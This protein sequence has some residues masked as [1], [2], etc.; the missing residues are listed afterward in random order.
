MDLRSPSG[1]R[2]SVSIWLPA[3][4]SFRP[5]PPCRDEEHAGRA[6]Q[7]GDNAIEEVAADD[8]LAPEHRE[9]PENAA[10]AKSDTC[11]H[12]WRTPRGSGDPNEVDQA[13]R[14]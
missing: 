8:R 4:R 13:H 2:F 1:I 12:E 3:E 9:A 5:P 10:T 14:W 11:R 6:V 7:A